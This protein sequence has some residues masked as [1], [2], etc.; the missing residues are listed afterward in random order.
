MQTEVNKLDIL[1]EIIYD[2]MARILKNLNKRIHIKL[3]ALAYDKDQKLVETI[4]VK[5]TVAK[6]NHKSSI[7]QDAMQNITNV[8][9]ELKIEPT[10]VGNTYDDIK[11]YVN[12]NWYKQY[13]QIDTNN[14]EQPTISLPDIEAEHT[15]NE[16]NHINETRILYANQ[17]PFH[18]DKK[19]F[20]I[21]YII[22]IRNVENENRQ[23]FYTKPEISFLR[24]LFDYFFSD[25]FALTDN[26][27]KVNND[28]TVS[29]KYN[30]DS[31]QFN[32]R[33]TRLFFG[34]MQNYLLE[35]TSYDQFGTN[36]EQELD[37][38]YYVNNLLE[39]MDD[40][41]TLTYESAS[42]FGSIL[43]MNKD[44]IAQP[45][46]ISFTV[47]FTI[48]D[49]I[50][51]EDA[52][53]IRK[54][55]ELT[56]VDKDLY[57]IADENE[58]YG[59]GEVNWN[60]QKDA[61]TL[62][63]DFTG[64]SKYN[65]NLIRTETGLISKGKL[66]VEDE[67]KFYRSDLSLVETNLISVSFK[68]PR[69]G[70]EGYSSEKFKNLLKNVFWENHTDN[71]QISHKLEWLDTIVRKARE[72]KQGTMVVIT[73]P[74][75]AKE[76]MRQLSKQSTLIEPGIIN[77]EYIKFLTAIDGAIYFDVDGNCHAIGVILDGVAKEDIGDSSR[78]ARYNSAQRYLQKLKDNGH[79]KCVIVIISEDG[80]VDLIPELEHEDMLLDIAEEI[81]DMINEED[82]DSD[83]LKEK[84]DLLLQSK[85]VDSD[86]LFNIAKIYFENSNADR[87]INFLEYGLKRAE[88]N[89]IPAMYYNLLGTCY[90]TIKRYED[91]INM[92]DLAINNPENNKLKSIYL[93][94]IGFS[95]YHL[96]QTLQDTE[97]K[98]EK[99]EEAINWLSQSIELMK[100]YSTKQ[101]VRNYNIRNYSKRNYNTR[102]ICYTELNYLEKSKEKKIQYLEDSIEDFSQVIKLEPVTDVLYWNRSLSYIQL[103]QIKGSIDDLI[104]AEYIKH[105]D[106][107]INKLTQ[108]FDDH[109]GLVTE[110]IEFYQKLKGQTEKSTQLSELISSYIAK[111]E[112]SKS[113]EAA[114]DKANDIGTDED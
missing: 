61:L 71:N 12:H 42:P 21:V 52:K 37:N 23:L 79:K 101:F 33:L 95:Y 43:F 30:E 107:Y 1:N 110:S 15:V 6:V 36:F 53:R 92:Y 76:E 69:L 60:L 27:V 13:P 54:L 90:R 84:E 81:I 64:L 98:T 62:R 73:E 102:G 19:T 100:T 111:I 63:L 82:A 45:S 26:C 72:Q 14:E 86:W 47:K 88:K 59:L 74:K 18:A 99:F 4:R 65:F 17:I 34:K 16:D 108:L 11:K 112:V 80:M 104:Q 7:S 40:I 5:K 57:L 32:R 78:G 106:K 85:I 75:T 35:N 67:K 48:E 66:F 20:S 29:R 10:H 58:I 105:D 9:A 68:N 109:H 8:F 25:Y 41:S 22:E 103:G 94:N 77:Q 96:A 114:A 24:M 91:A 113:N 46:I 44:I 49:R 83:K 55:L 3:Y 70:E 39:K 89:Y 51:L 38:Q 31:I 2:N 93:S 87:A 50:R 28:G 97:V 56:N